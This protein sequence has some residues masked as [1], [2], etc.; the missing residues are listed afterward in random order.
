MF[1]DVTGA[2][3]ADLSVALQDVPASQAMENGKIMPEI[4]TSEGIA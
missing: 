3:D 2:S 1:Q 4:G